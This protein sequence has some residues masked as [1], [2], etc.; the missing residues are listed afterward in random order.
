M[1]GSL[2]SRRIAENLYG[3]SH[4]VAG[5]IICEGLVE[6]EIDEAS[7]QSLAIVMVS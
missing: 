6:E 5:Y 7:D 2:V 1:N 3:L 4:R